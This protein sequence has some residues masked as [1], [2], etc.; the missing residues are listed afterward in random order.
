MIVLVMENTSLLVL[1]K[2]LENTY[3]PSEQTQQRIR[4]DIS[5]CLYANSGDVENPHVPPLHDLLQDMA[6]EAERVQEAI[7]FSDK[8]DLRARAVSGEALGIILWAL[9][10]EKMKKSK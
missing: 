3:T 5:F 7:C 4:S 10:I 6:V 9:E 8:F 2:I 1:E